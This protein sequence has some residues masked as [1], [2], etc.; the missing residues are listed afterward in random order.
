MHTI[1]QFLFVFYLSVLIKPMES[2]FQHENHQ[3]HGYV[4]SL[5]SQVSLLRQ[6]LVQNVCHG[7]EEI[8]E[9]GSWC[10]QEDGRFLSPDRPLGLSHA[11]ADSGLEKFLTIMFS[12]FRIFDFGAGVGQYGLAFNSTNNL[13]GLPAIDYLGFDGALNVPE[14]TK[15]FIKWA[16]FTVPFVPTLKGPADWV[17]CLEVGE[18][19]PQ[20]FE[21]ILLG[22]IHN[23]NICGA[24]LSWGI[25]GQ[26]GKLSISSS[27][28]YI[29]ISLSHN[30]SQ[31]HY[32]TISL[33]QSHYYTA[34]LR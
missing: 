24:I 19:I 25:P 8:L 31:S 3:K 29:T 5:E 33:S 22:N 1:R 12:G 7:N 6:L 26:G 13:N 9:T 2:L 27:S 28:S 34:P 30:L 23:N 32:F 17:L 11:A 21:S 4:K 20:K 18:H 15:G 10:L 14:F 16:D